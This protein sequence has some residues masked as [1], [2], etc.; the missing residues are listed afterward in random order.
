MSKYHRLHKYYN[1]LPFWNIIGAIS[2]S[3]F[4]RN[5]H[6]FSVSMYNS[7]LISLP[8]TSYRR[9]LSDQFQPS[10]I[11]MNLITDTIL[12]LNISVKWWA[13]IPLCLLLRAQFNP[14]QYPITRTHKP[15]AT[16]SISAAANTTTPQQQQH[17][18]SSNSIDSGSNT[19]L[20]AAGMPISRNNRV[21]RDP[22]LC[23]RWV[24]CNNTGNRNSE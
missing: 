17:D 18:D 2:C 4:T 15:R 5:C 20:M 10:S 21:Y 11:S 22:C 9:N 7:L 6:L 3:R 1:L 14:I 12:S 16:G 23:Q 19:N 24:R 8:R 13:R